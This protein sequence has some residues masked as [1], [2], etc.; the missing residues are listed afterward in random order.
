[1]AEDGETT[2][3]FAWGDPFDLDGQLSE[4]E[5]LMRDKARRK[6]ITS[7]RGRGRVPPWL[8]KYCILA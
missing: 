1:M 2:C 7:R 3:V 8:K 6:D 4:D 5:K